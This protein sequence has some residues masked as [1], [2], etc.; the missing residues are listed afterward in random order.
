M[1]RWM[2]CKMRRDRIEIKKL[3][4]SRVAP[5][6]IK[7]KGNS[8]WFGHVYGW[9]EHTPEKDIPYKKGGRP[10]KLAEMTRDDFKCGI[11]RRI[12]QTDQRK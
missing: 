2:S 9:L 6:W 10:E 12:H 4:V 1:E 3:E 7:Y 5:I 11:Q 8:R